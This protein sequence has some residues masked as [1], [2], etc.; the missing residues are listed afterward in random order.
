M[1]ATR[2]PVGA[3]LV[4]PGPLAPRHVDVKSVV[5]RASWKWVAERLVV[6]LGA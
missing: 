6:G 1:Q 4:S 5:E 3:P 2:N